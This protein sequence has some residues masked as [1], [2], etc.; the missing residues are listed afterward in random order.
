MV[1]VGREAIANEMLLN[2]LLKAGVNIIR[3]NCAHDDPSVWSEIVRPA[4]HC[5]QMLEKPC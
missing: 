2:D 4:K 1:I 3:I 5:L